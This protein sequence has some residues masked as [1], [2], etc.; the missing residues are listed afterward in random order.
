MTRQCLKRIAHA[1]IVLCA[2][3]SA[4][5]AVLGEAIAAED[6]IKLSFAY[7]ASEKSWPGPV[8]TQW[9]ARIRE[10]TSGKVVVETFPNGTLLGRN[11][12]FDGVETGV[13][14][15]GMSIIKDPGRFP[16]QYGFGLPLNIANAEVG[17][18]MIFD[19]VKEFDPDELKGFK[20]LAVFSSGPGYLQTRKKITSLEDIQGQEIRGTGGGV[21]VL[22]KLGANPVGMSIREVAQALQTGVINGYMTSLTVIKDF[23]LAEMVG[24]VTMYPMNVVT[25]AVVMNRG[26]WEALPADVQAAVDRISREISIYG[27]SI[28]DKHEVEAVEWAKA[29]H[30]V[31]IHELDADEAAR[32]NEAVAPLIGEWIDAQTA[33]GLP[34]QE[35]LNRLKELR[36]ELK[37]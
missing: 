32:W 37:N 29:E 19:L 5:S 18:K 21:A 36:T 28:Y 33:R 7:Y 3:V 14:D 25:F 34:A 22:R 30:G 26:K 27:G 2:S 15:I 24:H 1:F 12:M 10:E 13:V 17:S 16:L 8:I 35:F 6:S 20:V 9:A 23:K 31:E 11:E 4:G